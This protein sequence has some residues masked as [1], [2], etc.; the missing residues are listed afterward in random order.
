MSA[1]VRSFA[2][3]RWIGIHLV[4]VLVLSVAAHAQE[5]TGIPG[6]F[7]VGDE[8]ALDVQAV[9]SKASFTDTLK[10]R[11][12]L[13]ITLRN[14]G[15]VP[16]KGVRRADAKQY[17]TQ[18]VGKYL[19]NATVNATV[20]IRIGI[21]GTAVARP[22]F[23]MI[24]TDMVFSDVV[25]LGGFGPGAD[26][27]RSVVK[28]NDHVVLGGKDVRTALSSGKTIND[29]PVRANDV[30]EVGEKSH[31]NWAVITQIA[32]LGLAIATFAISLSK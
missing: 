6:E 4:A 10:V 29:L 21:F 3:L 13:V 32:G 18:A 7:Q 31:T 12:G 19:K 2:K 24:P 26:P 11:D 22:N 25:A 17:L 20:L 8:I 16:L 27:A 23:Y 28:R 1:V 9:D 30:V 14:L 5:S 15:D